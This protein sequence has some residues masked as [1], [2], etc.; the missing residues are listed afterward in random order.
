RPPIPELIRPPIPILSRPWIP[1]L[2]RPGCRALLAQ[3]FDVGFCWRSILLRGSF[4]LFAAAFIRFPFPARGSGVCAGPF[5]AM[6]AFLAHAFAFE[7]DPVRVMDDAVEDGVGI[8][9]VADEIVPFLDGRLAG[10]DGGAA[11]IALLDEFE[12]G[13]AGRGVE[14]LQ[15][16]IVED[17]HLGADQRPNAPCLGHYRTPRS[18]SLVSAAPFSPRCWSTSRLRRSRAGSAACAAL[19]SSSALP[20]PT[21]TTSP[22]PEEPSSLPPLTSLSTASFPHSPD[23]IR[24]QSDKIWL[25]RD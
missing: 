3:E 14:N 1:E 8:G 21:A 2:F 4:G 15:T 17:E 16:K 9:G 12:E 5:F 22:A 7:L 11:A 19:V 23:A 25:V 20:K 13:V 6:G 24:A 18:I 10:D